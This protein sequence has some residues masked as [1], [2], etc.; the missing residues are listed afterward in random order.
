MRRWRQWMR[1]LTF[2]IL[3]VIAVAGMALRAKTFSAGTQ[4]VGATAGARP[5]GDAPDPPD[6]NTPTQGAPDS[7]RAIVARGMAA[8]P[9]CANA[10]SRRQEE[11]CF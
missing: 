3:G 10:A 2:I 1:L 8:T 11:I 9:R 6:P 4:P 7:L 5:P